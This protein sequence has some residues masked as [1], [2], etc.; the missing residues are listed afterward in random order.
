M[1]DEYNLAADDYGRAI[2]LSPD[3]PLHYVR[4]G[5]ALFALGRLDNAIQ[6]FDR[7]IELYEQT[8]KYL[9][10]KRRKLEEAAKLTPNLAMAYNNRRRA[11][12]QLGH[13]E[14]AI[15]DH[16]DAIRLNSRA[17]EFCANRAFA[18]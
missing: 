16:D 10:D 1:Q 14:R 8:I 7:A 3:D 2:T 6:D 5:V 12:Y 4:R 13:I 9:R 17:A 11:C 18:Y 15:L